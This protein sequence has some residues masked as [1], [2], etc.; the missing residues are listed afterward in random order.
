MRPKPSGLFVKTMNMSN[1]SNPAERSMNWSI[2]IVAGWIPLIF[3]IWLLSLVIGKTGEAFCIAA[4]S[5]WALFSISGLCFSTYLALF[6][7]FVPEH[8]RQSLFAIV[9]AF[10]SWSIE[11]PLS[12]MVLLVF[13]N[14][15]F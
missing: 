7:F 4:M 15:S 12:L 9:I 3:F 11:L 5:M 13:R 1:K 14:G 8:R 6:A 2:C 10:L